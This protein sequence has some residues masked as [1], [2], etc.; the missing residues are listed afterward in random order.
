MH[1]SL[2]TITKELIV[3][4]P[5]RSVFVW[6]LATQMQSTARRQSVCILPIH[7]PEMAFSRQIKEEIALT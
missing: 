1:W 3:I 7:N 4:G 6:R 2:L 5:G